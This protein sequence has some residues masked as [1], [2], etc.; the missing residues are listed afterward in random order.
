MQ[1][2]MKSLQS[3]GSYLFKFPATDMLFGT[4]KMAITGS[5]PALARRVG[6]RRKQHSYLPNELSDASPSFPAKWFS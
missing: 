3:S 6:R 2:L 5:A 4:A 1:R